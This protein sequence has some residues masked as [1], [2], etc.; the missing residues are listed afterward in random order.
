MRKEKRKTISLRTNGRETYARR[1][2]SESDQVALAIH[3]M[4]E[5]LQ[6]LKRGEKNNI[7]VGVKCLILYFFENDV[8]ANNMTDSGS[9]DQS[10]GSSLFI[11]KF[12]RFEENSLSSS[13]SL[14]LASSLPF[15]VSCSEVLTWFGG[16]RV[17]PKVPVSGT[18]N[19]G[20]KSLRWH[21]RHYLKFPTKIYSKAIFFCQKI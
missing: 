10:R 6:K 19:R 18:I 16:Q 9:A 17:P 7:I 21:P 12:C 4:F 13:A 15:P 1:P 3:I 20:I 2:A 8:S 5:L 14:R 11:N